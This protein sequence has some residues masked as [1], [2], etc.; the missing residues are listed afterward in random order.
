MSA[1]QTLQLQLGSNARTW[2]VTGVAGFV[3]CNLLEALLKLDQQV[4]GLDN[5][6]TGR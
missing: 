5:F 4:V 3:G 1:Y 6:A 2:L